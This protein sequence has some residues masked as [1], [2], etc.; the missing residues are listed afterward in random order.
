[1][2]DTGRSRRGADRLL[3]WRNAASCGSI[4]LTELWA[5]DDALTT[6]RAAVFAF[7]ARI[8]TSPGSPG[9]EVDFKAIARVWRP[10]LAD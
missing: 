8:V 9:H 3:A 10:E 2:T 1:M 7:T 6:D 5:L 4:D